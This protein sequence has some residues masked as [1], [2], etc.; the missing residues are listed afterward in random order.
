MNAV[1][2]PAP[3]P[4]ATGHLA[5]DGIP[6]PRLGDDAFLQIHDFLHHVLDLFEARY[7]DQ[8]N[9]FYQ[10]LCGDGIFEPNGSP[11]LDDPPF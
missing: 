11:S 3:E 4:L 10:D 8:I 2:D 1:P 9:R 7:G 6:M 5:A